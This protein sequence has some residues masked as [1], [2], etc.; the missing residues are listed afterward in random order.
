VPIHQKAQ[1]PPS[2]AEQFDTYRP[3]PD[4]ERGRRSMAVYRPTRTEAASRGGVMGGIDFIARTRPV[5]YG[6]G[7]LDGAAIAGM[8]V[9]LAVR[10][11]FVGWVVTWSRS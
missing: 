7:W 11:Q 4:D 10:S 8:V 5:R 9:A 2:L 1:L 6:P 3:D